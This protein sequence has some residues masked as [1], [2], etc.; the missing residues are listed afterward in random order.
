MIADNTKVLLEI[1]KIKQKLNNQGQNI[2][3]VF[4]YL[5]ELIENKKETQPR[6]TIGYLEK[7]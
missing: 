1:E 4:K 7:N 3:L 5:D 2:E 6:K